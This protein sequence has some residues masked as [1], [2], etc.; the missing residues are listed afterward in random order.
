MTEH[1]CLP[2]RALCFAASLSR[3]QRLHLAMTP[4]PVLPVLSVLTSL[5]CLRIAS[6]GDQMHMV[7]TGRPRCVLLFGFD[8]SHRGLLRYMHQDALHQVL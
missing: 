3:L 2:P 1:Y 4:G 6:V 7:D 5:T 8:L